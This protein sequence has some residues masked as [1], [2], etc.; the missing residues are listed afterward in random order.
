MNEIT[1]NESDRT[2]FAKCPVCC[3][4]GKGVPVGD[5]YCMAYTRRQWSRNPKCENCETPMRF[6]YEIPRND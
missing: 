3:K 2:F 6:L 1:L 4:T 5:Y